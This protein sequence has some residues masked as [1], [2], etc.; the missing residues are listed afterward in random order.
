[1]LTRPPQLLRL[2]PGAAPRFINLD[3]S[4]LIYEGPIALGGGH[5]DIFKDDVI[6]LI[7]AITQ[8]P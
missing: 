6:Y 8:L 2:L 3:A 5:G 7:W 1:M 4:R